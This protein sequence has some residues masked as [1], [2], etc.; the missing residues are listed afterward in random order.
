MFFVVGANG[1]SIPESL[2]SD[3]AER[4]PN[5][6]LGVSFVISLFDR[7]SWTFVGRGYRP[8]PSHA[9]IIDATSNT[10][11]IATSSFSHT[12]SARKI[13]VEFDVDVDFGLGTSVPGHPCAVHLPMVIADSI[14]LVIEVFAVSSLRTAP[15]QRLSLGWTCIPC[16]SSNVHEL[17]RSPNS[18][19]LKQTFP[20]ST[21]TCSLYAGSP[22][23]LLCAKTIGL[24]SIWNFSLHVILYLSY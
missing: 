5:S 23:L 21:E 7:H 3:I 24:Y 13:S 15:I 14:C 10:S 1:L 4:I 19:S 18:S 17:P 20:V 22:V 16:F 11:S 8:D 12:K 2:L 9:Q 6:D